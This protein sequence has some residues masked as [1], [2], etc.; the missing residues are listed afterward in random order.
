MNTNNN[1]RLHAIL[2]I[3]ILL[4]AC[5]G[6]AAPESPTPTGSATPEPPA[7]TGSATPE[8]PA[9][10]GSATP[11]PPA[12]TGITIYTAQDIDNRQIHFVWLE[13]PENLE[14]GSNDVRVF[15]AR[16]DPPA[17]LVPT[18]V[19]LPCLVQSN[20][21]YLEFRAETLSF[22][23]DGTELVGSYEWMACA[24]C[25]E[26]YMNWNTRMEIV[27]LPTGDTMAIAIGI[28]HLGHNIL[29]DFTEIELQR[30]DPSW[31]EPAIQCRRT[32]D[33]LEVEF[34]P[35]P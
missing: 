33:C 5:S 34:L 10:T 23:Y 30:E 2:F 32:S 15:M 29:Q 22:E 6:A 28:R 24:S 19:E 11:E 3:A 8:P 4:G 25:V 12:P 7:P 13:L 35:R 9:P 17:M 20:D 18:E 27:G 26:C 31:L 14:V 21:G 1:L 16:T